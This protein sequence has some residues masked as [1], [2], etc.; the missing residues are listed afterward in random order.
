MICTDDPSEGIFNTKV[1]QEFAIAATI[2]NLTNQQLLE[3]VFGAV[4]AAFL[5]D[6]EKKALKERMQRHLADIQQHT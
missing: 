1:S 6:S 4:D 2:F 3:L 5:S